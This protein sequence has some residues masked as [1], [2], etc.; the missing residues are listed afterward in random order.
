MKT[1]VYLAVRCRVC[2]R[3]HDLY[4][5]RDAGRSDRAAY[6]YDCPRLRVPVFFRPDDRPAA[7]V[8]A[9]PPGAVALRW[10]AN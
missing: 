4:Y 9:L 7:A 2:G 6:A 3:T 1:D 5:K 8:A 10:V